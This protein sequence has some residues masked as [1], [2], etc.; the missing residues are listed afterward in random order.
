ME[1]GG[2]G[3]LFLLLQPTL[4]PHVFQTGFIVLFIISGW[5]ERAR[6]FQIPQE[7]S[8]RTGN[9]NSPLLSPRSLTV[10]RTRARIPRGIALEIKTPRREAAKTG[11][12]RRPLSSSWSG[13]LVAHG[14]VSRDDWEPA[15]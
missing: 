14:R 8:G 5:E 4:Q 9:G 13:S 12:V 1:K 2:C 6:A 11:T 15:Q 3:F 7:F 10:A